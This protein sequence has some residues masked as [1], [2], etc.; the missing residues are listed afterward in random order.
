MGTDCLFVFCKSCFQTK[1]NLS[2]WLSGELAQRNLG[3][4]YRVVNL[5]VETV[6]RNGDKDEVAVSLQPES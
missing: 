1:G 3:W 4:Q 5:G 6:L 2:S